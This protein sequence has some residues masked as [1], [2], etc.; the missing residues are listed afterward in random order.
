MYSSDD[1]LRAKENAKRV[2]EA[3]QQLS[4]AWCGLQSSVRLYPMLARGP[5]ATQ[6]NCQ[7]A[8]TEIR[9]PPADPTRS[10]ALVPTAILALAPKFRP[11]H[12]LP[13]SRLTPRTH[14][15]RS[16]N[17]QS[18]NW[19]G[20]EDTNYAA[21]SGTASWDGLF[22]A[23][24]CIK[25]LVEDVSNL[26]LVVVAGC[27]EEAGKIDFCCRTHGSTRKLELVGGIRLGA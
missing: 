26:V 14:I 20:P 3:E 7:V 23:N 4:P 1:I 9:G 13:P 19:M 8:S 16:L 22:G 24:H 17:R 18:R 10:H 25:D 2:N 21:L 27:Q 5:R 11:G 12:P 6:T 15:C